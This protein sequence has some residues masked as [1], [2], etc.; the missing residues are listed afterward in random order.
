MSHYAPA[1]RIANVKYAIRNIVVKA[2][3]L[4]STGK[5]ITYLNIG[6]PLNYDFQTPPHM[7]EAVH[8]SMLN[9]QTNGYAPSC[10]YLEAIDSIIGFEE[11]LGKKLTREH[12][13]ITTG[14]SEGIELA[15]TALFNPGEELL[16]PAP[17]YPL[18]SAVCAKLNVK[19]VAYNLDPANWGLDLA[20]IESKITS[21]TKAIVI[22]NPNNPTGKI[23]DQSELQ[24]LVE[25][26]KK[27]HL[28][29]FSDEIYNL[30]SF[31]KAVISPA[32]LTSE[33]P[34]ICFN[35]LAKSFLVPGWRVGWITCS[36]S[37]LYPQ[38]LQA[39]KQLADARLC[40]PA[41]GQYAIKAA[42]EG[43]RDHIVE[44]VEKL[45]NRR[46]LCVNALRAIEGMSVT[47]PDGAFYLMAK[48]DLP[49]GYT[50]EQFILELLQATGVLFVHGS[51][52]G[53]PVTQGFFRIVFLPSQDLIASAMEKVRTFCQ[54]INRRL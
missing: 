26:A 47:A 2:K 20:D 32:K 23:Y 35:G 24:Q 17:G 43:P 21:Q 22:I 37:H 11:K 30:L 41:P 33:V 54:G 50:D 36:N 27:H 44:M 46:D 5:T 19:E 7:I 10:G 4:E 45:V 42:L 9:G 39:I 25:I 31:G 13:I 1:S 16:V 15:L 34:V 52:F 3:A 8:Q 12:V 14:A 48:F 49:T 28:I 51:G 40:S 6:D 38:Y 53:M 18:Y 29:I